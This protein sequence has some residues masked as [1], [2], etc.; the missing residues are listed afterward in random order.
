MNARNQTD[1]NAVAAAFTAPLPSWKTMEE[2]L[3]QWHEQ[4]LNDPEYLWLEPNFEDMA[5]AVNKA[6]FCAG[7]PRDTTPDDSW[8]ARQDAA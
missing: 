2:T 7:E 5:D 3:R 4:S 6:M 1:F 8:M